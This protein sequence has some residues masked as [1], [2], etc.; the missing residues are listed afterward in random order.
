MPELLAALSSAFEATNYD[1]GAS[2][3]NQILAYLMEKR[4]MKQVDLLPVPG[5]SKGAFPD[6]ISGRREISRANAKK[7]A[8]FFC[9]P[10]ALFI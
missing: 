8:G 3:P 9:A 7:L 6:I 2:R 5:C 1:L 4:G 10:V